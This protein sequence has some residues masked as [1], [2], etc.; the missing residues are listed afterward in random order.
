MQ[1]I[2]IIFSSPS[3]SSRSSVISCPYYFMFFLPLSQSKKNIKNWCEIQEKC[4]KTKNIKS[5]HNI[6]KEIKD[7]KKIIGFVSCWPTTTKNRRKLIF[8]SASKYQLYMISWLGVGPHVHFPALVLGPFWFEAVQ[9]LCI[10]P[11]SL[12]VHMCIHLVVCRRQ[13]HWSLPSLLV[14]T[15]FTFPPWLDPQVLREG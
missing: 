8:P 3:S 7:L 13:F 11:L 10:Q 6:K 4:S 12:W 1:C 9:V 5:K 15:I 2:L 14:L